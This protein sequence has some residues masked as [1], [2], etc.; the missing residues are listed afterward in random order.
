LEFVETYF[1]TEAQLAFTFDPK[2]SG[3]ALNSLENLYLFLPQE[4]GEPVLA[5]EL[6]K[7][8]RYLIH[9]TTPGGLLNYAMG[10][11]VE[12][13]STR[14]LLIRVAGREKEELSMT[15]EKI[16]LEQVDLALEEAGLNRSR[17][18]GLPAILWIEEENERPHLVW[19]IPTSSLG[20][21][22][23]TWPARLDE[24]L[25]AHNSLYTEAL[26]HEQV[27]GPSRLALLPDAV[28]EDYGKDQLGIGQFK[29]KRFFGSRAEVAQALGWLPG[30]G[31]LRPGV[32]GTRKSD[33]E[34]A[35]RGELG[36]RRGEALELPARAGEE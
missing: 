9:V 23:E 8:K 1:A 14:P 25:C 12:V 17:L 2:V 31:D 29:R 30:S 28:L 6:E 34:G 13:I 22:P 32:Q 33:L 27:I 10:D 19:G 36:L 18:H 11:V 7:G 20:A 35:T 26:R 5:H 3:L 16:S 21:E 15:G 24:L 4:G